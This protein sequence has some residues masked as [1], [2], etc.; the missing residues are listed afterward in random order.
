MK[1]LRIISGIGI[2]WFPFWYFLGYLNTS[3]NL[4]STAGLLFFGFGYAVVHAIISMWYGQKYRTKIIVVLSIIGIVLYQILSI[5]T[6]TTDDFQTT[7]VGTYFFGSIY[8]IIFSIITFVLS[9]KKQKY[10]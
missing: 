2:V 6:G 1:V 8:A 10:Y 9:F 5:S 4:Q 7:A 3:Q